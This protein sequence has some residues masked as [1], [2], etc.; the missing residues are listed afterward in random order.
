MEKEGEVTLR[1]P[2]VMPLSPP[3]FQLNEVSFRYEGSKEDAPYL[4]TGVNLTAA[5]ESRICIVGENGA[6]KTTLLKIVTGVLS[7]T[8]GTVHAHRNLKIGYFSQHHV[9]QLDMS[10]CPVELIQNHFPGTARKMITK[11]RDGI[12][13]ANFFVFNRVCLQGNRSKNTGECSV[14]SELREIWP[15]KTSTLYPVAKNRE[16]LLL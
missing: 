7:P 3:I 10:V 11:K 4:F 14:A 6:G 12:S 16:S 8:K 9:D 1:F 2:D 5:L 13:G 15:C